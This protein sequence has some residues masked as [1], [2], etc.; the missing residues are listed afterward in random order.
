MMKDPEW[1]ALIKKEYFR[2]FFREPKEMV[3]YIKK[4]MEVARIVYGIKK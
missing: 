3:E 4:E 2:P 1:Q